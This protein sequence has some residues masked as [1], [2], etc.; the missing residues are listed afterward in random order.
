MIPLPEKEVLK[1]NKELVELHKRCLITHLSQLG[2]KLKIRRKFF[3]L[4]DH[5]IDENNI[6]EYFFRDLEVFVNA[7]VTDRLEQI[8]DYFKSEPI[9]K[10]R[11]RNVR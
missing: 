9:K 11:R 6:R 3:K 2:I 8:R 5:F 10:R 7:L 4:Y 1:S